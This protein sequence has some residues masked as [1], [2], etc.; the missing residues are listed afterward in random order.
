MRKRTAR[1]WKRT[2]ARICKRSRIPRIRSLWT[3]AGTDRGCPLSVFSENNVSLRGCRL[4][5]RGC[6]LS[7]RGCRLSLRGCRLSL[8]NDFNSSVSFKISLSG[9]SDSS[10]SLS[11]WSGYNS[12]L[13]LS[14]ACGNKDRLGGVF[15]NS[16]G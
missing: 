10:V 1:M 16:V 3:G 5:F 13:G 6:R 12:K 15:K 4:S 9:V 14:D 2:A 11:S 7:F 8:S